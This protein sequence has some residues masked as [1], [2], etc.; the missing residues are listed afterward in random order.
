LSLAASQPDLSRAIVPGEVQVEINLWLPCFY[1]A[2]ILNK[3]R[4]IDGL[5]CLSIVDSGREQANVIA[6]ATRTIFV[7]SDSWI[8]EV[9]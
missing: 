4:T 7:P 6:K 9:S 8:G 3:V 2:N 5:R 1:A